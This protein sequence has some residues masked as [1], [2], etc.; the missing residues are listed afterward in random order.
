MT[1]DSYRRLLLYVAGNW[2]SRSNHTTSNAS[3]EITS[4]QRLALVK[5]VCMNAP[6]F[7]VVENRPPRF[8]RYKTSLKGFEGGSISQIM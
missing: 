5:N 3:E 7:R 2:E 1:S 8:D 4:F 6:T